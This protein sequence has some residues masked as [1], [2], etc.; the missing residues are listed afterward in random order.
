M[1]IAIP[2]NG[3]EISPHFGRC[4][5]FTLIT[6]EDGKIKERER[7]TTQGFQHQHE[8]FASFLKE[9]GVEYIITGG[10]GSRARMALEGMGF[11]IISG[12]EGEIDEAVKALLQG[13][14]KTQSNPCDREERGIC[15]RHHD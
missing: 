14:L 7:I 9:K 13:T 5:V 12:V 3:N 8:E 10:I 6:V 15:E 1:K 4:P 2:T 11:E